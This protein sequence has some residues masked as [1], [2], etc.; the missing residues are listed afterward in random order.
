MIWVMEPNGSGLYFS[1]VL[2]R[3]SKPGLLFVS[4]DLTF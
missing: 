4:F 2:S 1:K 3:I